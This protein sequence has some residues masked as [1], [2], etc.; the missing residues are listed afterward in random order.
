MLGL[1]QL[2]LNLIKQKKKQN[3]AVGIIYN[4]VKFTHSKPLMRDRNTLNVYQ[5]NIFQVLKFMFKIG[6]QK[7]I[8][9]T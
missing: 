7:S 4:K 1:A 8:T 9:D 5:I 2:E 3:H 6:L